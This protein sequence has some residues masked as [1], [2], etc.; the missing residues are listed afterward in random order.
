MADDRDSPR[1]S[2]LGA[3][4]REAQARRT[5]GNGDRG[6]AKGD[7]PGG[8]LGMAFRVGVELASA[9]AVG[10]GIG[11]LL[12]RWLG[13]RPWLLIVFFFLGAGAGIANLVRL[14]PGFGRGDD[15]D[16]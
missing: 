10:V 12:D 15:R 9:L 7:L 11:W 3:R 14:L 5:A 6:G 8:V 16:T 4:I 2:A 1:L 13:T